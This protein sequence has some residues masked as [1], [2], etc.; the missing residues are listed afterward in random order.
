MTSND[1]RFLTLS[2]PGCSSCVTSYP[3]VNKE[4]SLEA[5]IMDTIRKMIDQ[6]GLY[7]WN[8]LTDDDGRPFALSNQGHIARL[9]P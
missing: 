7:V 5:A 9:Q 4:K 2:A 1:Y 8:I 6:F 3:L